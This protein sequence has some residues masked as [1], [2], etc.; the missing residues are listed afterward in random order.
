MTKIHLIRHGVTYWNQELRYQGH[1]DISLTPEGERQAELM[2]TSFAQINLRAIYSS[3][4]IRAQSTALKLGEQKQLSVTTNADFREINF[5]A[6]EGL[7]YEQIKAKWGNLID[8]F[9]RAPGEVYLPQG[10]GFGDVYKR[11]VPNLLALLERHQG[12]EIA[13]V[14][15][16]GIIRVLLCYVLGLPLNNCWR[17]KQDNT[18]INTITYFKDDM[19]MLERLND[20]HHLTKI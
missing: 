6:W 17:I 16:G 14:A 8:D 1:S 4:L 19:C 5:G 12:E 3:D 9:F 2:A 13:I 15:H 7:T 20:V 10:E 18:A 11:A